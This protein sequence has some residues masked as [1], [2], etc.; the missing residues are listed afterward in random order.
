MAD[1]AEHQ[2]TG[3]IEILN[4]I[5]VLRAK[6]GSNQTGYLLEMTERDAVDRQPTWTGR[7]V[8]EN[9]PAGN[10]RIA[11]WQNLSRQGLPYL[12][13]QARTV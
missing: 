9:S 10:R 13:L 7:I 6:I 3:Q 12:R 11:A 1:G 4:D 2:I 8:D 5:R